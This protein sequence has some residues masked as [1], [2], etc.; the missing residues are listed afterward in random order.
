MHG[1]S[2]D[3]AGWRAWI[4]HHQW[5][6]RSELAMTFWIS[7]LLMN[8]TAIKVATLVPQSNVGV[9]VFDL[10][11]VGLCGLFFGGLV[12]MKVTNHWRVQ[13]LEA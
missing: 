5:Q 1:G 4:L 3:N 12:P 2:L 11:G 9:L 13:A 6:C 8:L 10:P 7:S